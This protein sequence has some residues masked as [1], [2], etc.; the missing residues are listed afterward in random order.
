VVI[1]KDTGA[2]LNVNFDHGL[3]K[4]QKNDPSTVAGVSTDQMINDQ[5]PLFDSINISKRYYDFHLQAS[6]PAK[7]KGANTSVIIDLDG[8]LRPVGAPDLGCYEKQ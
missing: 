7:E 2:D 3:W 1:A 4:I 5:P 8:D 6:S